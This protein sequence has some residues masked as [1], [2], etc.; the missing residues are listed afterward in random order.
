MLVMV[1]VMFDDVMVVTDAEKPCD[2][3]HMTS[4]MTE[5]DG[6]DQDLGRTAVTRAADGQT[7]AGTVRYSRYMMGAGGAPARNGPGPAR[8]G[9]AP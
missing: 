8:N 9:R 1:L 3:S 4:T 2:G 5:V 6:R 7:I